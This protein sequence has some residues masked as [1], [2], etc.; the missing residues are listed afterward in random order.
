MIKRGTITKKTISNDNNVEN[1]QPRQTTIFRNDNSRVRK[2]LG[3]SNNYTIVKENEFEGLC[4]YLGATKTLV[5]Q[6]YN[7]I[8]SNITYI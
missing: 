5:G 3:Q 1:R 8:S 4:L 6:N 7:V 2:A